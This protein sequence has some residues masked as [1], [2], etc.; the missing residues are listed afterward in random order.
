MKSRL[1]IFAL[2]SLI[3]TSCMISCNSGSQ[4]RSESTKDKSI[5]KYRR[6]TG[7]VVNAADMKPIGGSII[8]FNNPIKNKPVGTLTDTEGKF[9]LDSIP[10]SVKKITVVNVTSNKSKEVELNE[11]DNILI[12]ME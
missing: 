9:V 6:I 5:I 8:T 11:E 12:K 10:N 2:L 3:L 7:K 4:N 1:F